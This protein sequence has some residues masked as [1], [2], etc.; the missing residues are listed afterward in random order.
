MYYELKKKFYWPK[1][2]LEIENVLKGCE[3]CQRVNRKKNHGSEFIETSRPFERVGVYL[4]DIR[5]VGKYIITKVDYFSRYYCC[6]I[7]EN[8]K[9]STIIGI[10]KNWCKEGIIAEILVSTT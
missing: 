7:I 6:E 2:K 10:L 5:S 3:M 9:S 4:I 1:I 8:K